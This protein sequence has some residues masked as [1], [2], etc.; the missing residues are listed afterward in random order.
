MDDLK[1]EDL[2]YISETGLYYFWILGAIGT[3]GIAYAIVQWS[4]FIG[5]VWRKLLIALAIIAL[6]WAAIS[7]GS[8]IYAL[9]T[10]E[11]F[12]IMYAIRAIGNALLPVIVAIVLNFIVWR[13]RS[14]SPDTQKVVRQ[15]SRAFATL[16][17]VV[18]STSR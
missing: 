6:L 18:A 5:Q 15:A 4:N 9:F 17:I 10:G 2:T 14:L 12:P 16:K 11:L 3:F 7:I 1:V 13:A 8:S